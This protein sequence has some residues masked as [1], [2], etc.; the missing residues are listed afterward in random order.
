ML[1]AIV[2]GVK[3]YKNN[4]PINIPTQM[5]KSAF[6]SFVISVLFSKNYD[7]RGGAV[8]GAL[9]ATTSLV[10]ALTM[11]FFRRF[12]AN[13]QGNI[14]WFENLGVRLVSLILTQ[15]LV[16]VAKP[17]FPVLQAYRIHLAA[18][19]VVLSILDIVI[20]NKDTRSTHGALGYLVWI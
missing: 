12:V 3:D 2:N 20:L 15:V 19:A 7:A 4:L 11:P 18:T 9:A 8:A 1:K 13:G 17:N 10:D 5:F 6:G 14:G 16:E